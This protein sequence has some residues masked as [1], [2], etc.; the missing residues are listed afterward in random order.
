MNIFDLV[1]YL[2][3]TD[4]INDLLVGQNELLESGCLLL[5]MEK[6]LEINSLVRIFSIEETEG[7]L[8]FTKGGVDYVE[9]IS[10]DSAVDFIESL[11]GKGM[12]DKELATMLFNYGVYDA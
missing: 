2:V 3:S 10:I 5:Y 6:S 7:N 8:S 9:L 11:K 4:K 1:E 12:N